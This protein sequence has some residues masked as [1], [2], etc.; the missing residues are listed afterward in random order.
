MSPLASTVVD[1][2]QRL[3]KLHDDEIYPLY[4]R[5]FGDLLLRLPTIPPHAAVREV[6]CAAGEVTA[7]VAR[8]LEGGGR[9]IALESSSALLEL[10][11]GKVA[12]LSV[13]KQVYFRQHRTGARLPFAEETFDNVLAHLSW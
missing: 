12:E 9:L 4:G 5:R 3:A 2:Q 8:R 6:G 10:A 13:S 7:E 1:R 11:R